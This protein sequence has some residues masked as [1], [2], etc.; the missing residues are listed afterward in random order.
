[1]YAWRCVLLFTLVGNLA[2]LTSTDAQAL[3]KTANGTFR[4]QDFEA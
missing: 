4:F 1:M 2:E 3:F